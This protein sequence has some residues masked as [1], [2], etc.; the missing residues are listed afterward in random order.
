[1]VSD[2]LDYLLG[3]RSSSA[4]KKADA[5]R[6]IAFVRRHSR[7][8]RSSCANRCAS[9]VV[10]PG[11]VPTSTSAWVT[12]P[13]NVSGLMPSYSPIRR[14]APGRDTGSHRAETANRIARPRSSPGYFLGA[15]T[16]LILSG[17]ESPHQTQG[18]TQR[19]H[20]VA[21]RIAAALATSAVPAP[22]A[23]HA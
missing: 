11:R 9:E 16:T 17:I 7:F 6:R 14:H 3:G 22:V 1:M 19:C 12:H 4:A 20:L 13:R 10:A 8:S 2:V 23:P 18:E 21:I 15:T 5:D